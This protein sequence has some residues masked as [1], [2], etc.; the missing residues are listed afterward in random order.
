MAPQRL[1]PLEQT[2]S[3]KKK[4]EHK[5]KHKH[6]KKGEENFHDKG[7]EKLKARPKHVTGPGYNRNVKLQPMRQM[8]NR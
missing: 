4:K 2:P 7:H 5:H 8:A 1:A 6:H 3:Q